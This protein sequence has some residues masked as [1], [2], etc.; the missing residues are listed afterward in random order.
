VRFAAVGASD[1]ISISNELFKIG[2]AIVADIFVNRHFH[3]LPQVLG[4]ILAQVG[5]RSGSY[6]AIQGVPPEYRLAMYLVTDP[7]KILAQAGIASKSNWRHIPLDLAGETFIRSEF[8]FNST[9]S[10][11]CRAVGITL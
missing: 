7:N 11:G 3:R 9:E 2:S 4:L 1:G 10:V 8:G 5:V 6:V